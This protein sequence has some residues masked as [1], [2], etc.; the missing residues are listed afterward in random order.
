MRPVRALLAGALLALLLAG[1]ALA[2]RENAKFLAGRGDK[3]LAAKK[4]DEAEGHFR[5]AL[6]EDPTFLAARYGLAQA[7]LGGGRSAP[8]LEEL[9]AFVE[10]AR[11]DAESKSLLAKAEKQLADLDAAG[12]A[13]Q[14]LVDGYA[15]DL[16]ALGDRWASKDPQLAE[17]AYRRAV[18]LKPGHARAAQGLEKMG[19]SAA[20][21]VIDLF[22]GKDLAG[23]EWMNPP[24]WQVVDGNLVATIRDAAVLARHERVFEG[25]FTVRIEAQL[26]EEYPGP[27]LYSVLPA[28][29]AEG[30]DYQLGLL[31]RNVLWC[32]ET[33]G[34]EDRDVVDKPYEQL[35]TTFDPKQWNVFEL[36]FRGSR[37]TALVNGEVIGEEARPER[38]KG[39]F[40][41]LK[42]Q[43]VKV[44]FRKVQVEVR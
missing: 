17:K 19:K 12:T 2:D 31:G 40:V 3:A 15:D 10:A 20:G 25:D 18:K 43:D 14:K 44:A 38:R 37:V 34:A 13:L 30:D 42:A 22:N 7:L 24:T 6:D 36:R 16:A 4:W 1:A 8:A 41:G 29:K 27:T 9:R 5:K 28:W 35:K 32:E 11:G 26:L 21:E 39:G 33:P 23:W